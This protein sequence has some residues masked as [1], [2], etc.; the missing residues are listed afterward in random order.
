ML[1]VEIESGAPSFEGKVPRRLVED[2]LCVRPEK[3]TTSVATK[4][5]LSTFDF[6]P[7]S[8]HSVAKRL[9]IL[10]TSLSSF[11]DRRRAR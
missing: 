7:D 5:G 8:K 2:L 9:L 11:D 4:P 1:K 10:Q 6:R 3:S